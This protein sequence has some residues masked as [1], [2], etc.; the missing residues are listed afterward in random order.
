MTYKAIVASI[1][2]RK[3]PNADRLKL[4]DAAGTSVVVGL[5]NYDGE[6]GILFPTDGQL[7]LEFCEANDLIGTKDPETGERKGGYF[8]HK[9]RVKTQRFRGERSEGYWTTLD[10]LAFTG[11]DI[12]K[13][14]EGDEFD[15][16][17]GIKLCNKYLTPATLRA[18]KGGTARRKN[19]WFPQ[20]VDTEN[21]KYHKYEIE[22]GS[23]CTITLKMH[24]TSARVAHVLDEVETPLNWW[25]KLLRRKPKTEVKWSHL[26]GSRRVILKDPTNTE[27]GY[28]GDEGFRWKAAESILPHLRKGEII[29]GELVGY[30]PDGHPLMGSQDTAPLKELKKKYGPKMT[31]SYGLPEGECKFYV[32]RICVITEDKHLVDYSWNQ[33][34]ARATQLG[35]EHV[36]EIM[37]PVILRYEASINSDPRLKDKDFDPTIILKEELQQRVIDTAEILAVGEDPIGKSH[38][39]EGVVVRLDK[40]NGDVVFLKNKSFEFGVLEGYIKQSEDYVDMEE[41]S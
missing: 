37:S 29:Y 24:G 20:H 28:Y 27:G 10:S 40:P 30:L 21:I 17:N 8:D 3:H 26:V 9:R 22:A 2:T 23:L 4:A 18:M 15:E 33:V 11:Y 19:E 38:I 35:L 39:R 12:S 1:K 6:L 16:L 31:Y 13:L 7:S 41:A 5:D 14:K 32:Y 36:P 34:K 25:R